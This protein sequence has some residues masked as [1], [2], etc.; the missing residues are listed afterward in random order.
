MI[1]ISFCNQILFIGVYVKI[2]NDRNNVI[3]NEK[4]KNI[5]KLVVTLRPSLLVHYKFSYFNL[6]ALLFL[7]VYIV[8]IEAN[9]TINKQ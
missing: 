6:F 9:N 8:V 2:W 1:D 4:Y 3:K 7:L 5:S